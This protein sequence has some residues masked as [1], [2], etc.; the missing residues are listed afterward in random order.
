MILLK[1]YPHADRFFS[2]NKV[3]T[4]SI[5]ILTKYNHIDNLKQFLV[6]FNRKMAIKLLPLHILVN[7]KFSI[8]DKDKGFINFN[9]ECRRI[10]ELFLKTQQVVF[11]KGLNRWATELNKIY[12]SLKG[13]PGA[14]IFPFIHLL[15]ISNFGENLTDL[16]IKEVEKR[17]AELPN[18]I[19]YLKWLENTLSLNYVE[20]IWGLF[21]THILGPFLGLVSFMRNGKFRRWNFYNGN[22]NHPKVFKRFLS[23]HKKD[24]EVCYSYRYSRG[25]YTINKKVTFPFLLSLTLNFD[26]FPRFFFYEG[27]RGAGI[28]SK[29]NKGKRKAS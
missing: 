27:F 11:K 1:K 29:R 7:I 19:L 25:I 10:N 21:L 18:E 20:I 9:P 26:L 2:T 28:Q 15:Y 17:K 24:L 14:Y 16:T 3:K 8:A 12:Y 4:R 23:F 5:A 6:K 22:F 13:T